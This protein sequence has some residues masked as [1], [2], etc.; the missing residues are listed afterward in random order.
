MHWAARRGQTAAVRAMFNYAGK[1]PLEL[2]DNDGNLALHLA[3]LN[4]H[5]KVSAWV[6]LSA[7]G[8]THVWEQSVPYPH[9]PM[10]FPVAMRHTVSIK[11]STHSA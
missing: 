3:A 1:V 11:H 6:P 9:V 10:A 8:P 4:N 7:C 2:K 5:E